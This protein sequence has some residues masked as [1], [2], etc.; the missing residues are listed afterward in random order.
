MRKVL[1]RLSVV[2]L[3]FVLGACASGETFAFLQKAQEKGMELSDE[4]FEKAALA[5]DVYCLNVPG[6]VRAFMRDGINGRTLHGDLVIEC[7]AQ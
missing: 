4:A 7:S 2:L 1:L 5:I 6:P 3:P